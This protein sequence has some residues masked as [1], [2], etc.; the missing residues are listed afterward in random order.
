MNRLYVLVVT[1]LVTGCSP[2]KQESTAV[3]AQQI[4]GAGAT[5]PA[6]IYQK[7]FGNYHAAHPD[8]EI[9]YQSI[10]SGAGIQQLT[11]GTVDFGAS[12]MP[13][14]DEQIADLKTKRGVDVLNLPTV[15][16]AVVPA[17]NVPGVTTDLKFTGSLLADIYLG[18]IKKWDDPAIAKVNPGV[19]FPSTDIVVVH[20][21]D[22]SG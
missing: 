1:L 9:N 7:W 2:A 16:G 5:F 6:P 22:S 10:G 3:P 19:K 8:V 11:S 4:T 12:D 21:S 17:Y 18:K 20:R 15:L 14:K 13:M